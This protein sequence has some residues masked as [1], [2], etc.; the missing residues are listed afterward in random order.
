MAKAK[1]AVRKAHSAERKVAKRVARHRE[2]PAWKAAGAAA[3][4]GDQPPLVA[5]NLATIALGAVFRRPEVVRTGVRMLA[6]HALAT[7]IKAAIKA[8]LDRTRPHARLEGKGD[9][10]GKGRHDTHDH[11][12]F[13]SGHTAGAVAVAAAVAR[14]HP[15][16]A[17]AA[18]GTAAA[19]AGVQVPRGSHYASDVAAGALVGWLSE[20]LTSTLLARG[21]AIAAKLTAQRQGLPP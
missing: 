6:A 18:H 3:E 7:G 10:L 1:Q 4:L 5:L 16:L 15:E 11:N 13:P 17:G 2:H 21:E 14:G 8:R 19:I 9:R 12:S 20:K